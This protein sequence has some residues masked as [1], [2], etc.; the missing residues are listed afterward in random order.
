MAMEEGLAQPEPKRESVKRKRDEPSGET[1]SK[2]TKTENNATQ[3]DIQRAVISY[4]QFA[5]TMPATQY[6]DEFMVLSR[7]AAQYNDLMETIIQEGKL[8]PETINFLRGRENPFQE[9]ISLWPVRKPVDLN[10]DILLKI[11]NDPSLSLEDLVQI[12]QVSKQFWI[13]ATNTDFYRDIDNYIEKSEKKWCLDPRIK[14]SQEDSAGRRISQGI[15]GLDPLTMYAVARH[16]VKI[17]EGVANQHRLFLPQGSHFQIIDPLD[18][19]MIKKKRKKINGEELF[20]EKFFQKIKELDQDRGISFSEMIEGFFRVALEADDP[21][22]ITH[23]DKYCW[24]KKKWTF[25]KPEPGRA[26]RAFFAQ[27]D[28]LLREGRLN[29]E[30]F[31]K[32]AI[33][34]PQMLNVYC[35]GWSSRLKQEPDFEYLNRIIK[36]KEYFPFPLELATVFAATFQSNHMDHSSLPGHL[37]FIKNC[38]E[39]IKSHLPKTQFDVFK[40]YIKTGGAFITLNEYTKKWKVE[41]SVLSKL[42]KEHLYNVFQDWESTNTIQNSEKLSSLATYILE[43]IEHECTAQSIITLIWKDYSKGLYSNRLAKITG[44]RVAP[45]LAFCRPYL[46]PDLCAYREHIE[47]L[48]RLIQYVNTTCQEVDDFYRCAWS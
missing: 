23:S 48:A 36:G 35:E 47:P 32:T 2:K 27:C 12:M 30:L 3:N 11:F 39:M 21:F 17:N 18:K 44:G 9:T 46:T 34:L 5:E 38:E 31:I 45:L 37:D 10:N 7:A 16:V 29:K 14:D 15:L 22:I 26:V 43:D 20:K 6:A 13:A 42:I 28:G 4:K 41:K 33:S 25:K 24:L 40:S 19:S 1:P 8:S